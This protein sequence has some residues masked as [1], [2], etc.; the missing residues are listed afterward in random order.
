MKGEA[1]SKK[2]AGT[3]REHNRSPSDT[4]AALAGVKVVYCAEEA[5][6]RRLLAEMVAAG[7]VAI[8]I[9]TAPNKTEVDR[10]AK[11]LQAKAETAGTLKA[12]ASSRRPRPRSRRSPP[13]ASASPS[14]FGTPRRLASTPTAPASGCFKSMPAATASSSSIS[15]TPAPASSTLLDGV[16][17][18]AH[19]VGLRAGLPG[20]GGR[21]AG[22]TPV[23]AAGDAPDAR[24]KRDEPRRRRS[25][26][27]EPRSRQDAADQRLER[28]PPVASSRSTTRRSTPSSRGGSPRKSCPAS[29]CSGP[30]T[31][32]R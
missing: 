20:D 14:R 29:T 19:N 5:Q 27:P 17:V 18:I 11:L 13:P 15:T 2:R 30:P 26:V 31:K 16:S 12:R 9:E 21:R 10:L 23:H 22:R 24:R 25:D 7:R 32:S 8:D 4:T 28:A 1:A 3:V 6:A